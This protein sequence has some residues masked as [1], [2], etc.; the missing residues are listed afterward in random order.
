MLS[1]HPVF[2]LPCS[3]PK[4]IFK[5]LPLDASESFNLS[6]KVFKDK[7]HIANIMR[8]LLVAARSPA[9]KIVEA[10][11]ELFMETESLRE[12]WRKTGKIPDKIT[13]RECPALWFVYAVVIWKRRVKTA[14]SSSDSSVPPKQ[15]F[16]PKFKLLFY[17]LANLNSNIVWQFQFI[18]N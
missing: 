14:E 7:I 8:A 16:T 3:M 11:N 10:I 17:S 5:L 2:S 13:K 1:G 6:W 18:K 15:K 9:W 12:T 4:K